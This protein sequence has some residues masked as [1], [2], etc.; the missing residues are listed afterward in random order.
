MSTEH[1]VRNTTNASVIVSLI[2]Q[3]D[4]EIKEFMRTIDL[5]DVDFV[6]CSSMYVIEKI[7]MLINYLKCLKADIKNK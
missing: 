2:K 5:D 3:K 7:D 1:V 4:K 6:G